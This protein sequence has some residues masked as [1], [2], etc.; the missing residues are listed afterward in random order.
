[1]RY[2][3]LLL[4]LCIPRILPTRFL[5][6]SPSCRELL[7][8]RFRH[9]HKHNHRMTTV[10]LNQIR[11]RLDV[12]EQRR[13][14]FEWKSEQPKRLS[15]HEVWRHA[16]LASPYLVGAPDDR[17]AE[18]F[19][20]VFLNV[21][22]IG[23]EGKICPVPLNQT[24]EFMQ[25]F[26]HLLEEYGVRNRDVPAS[27]IQSAREPFLKYFEHGTP[28]GV[29]MFAEY[30]APATPIL[31]KYGKRQHL[32][33]LL[34]D[35]T[36]RLA[37]AN[38]YNDADLLVAVRDD[39][40]SRTF[41]IPTYKER[42]EGK[43]HIT[44]Q[45]HRIEFGDDDLVLPL[46]FDDYFLF[47][48]CEHIHYRMPTDFDADAAIIIRNPGLFMER[49]IATFLERFPGWIPMA[50]KVTYYDPYRDYSKF[51]VPEMAKHFGYAYQKEVRVAFRP[52]KQASTA[53][54]PLFLS[55]G[56]MTDYADIVAI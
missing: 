5:H 56:S 43:S 30:D 44:F 10:S 45:G 52:R 49:L 40:T 12:M 39:E 27:L 9:V 4:K 23:P 3:R 55:I 46:V 14:H 36:L 32:E 51:S 7:R 41:F 6:A 28:I 16:Y 22:E 15:R 47:S 18:R 48:M 53:L 8:F 24:D 34:K 19:R 37:N 13:R 50:G 33:L 38:S 29:T 1:M 26:T 11:Q 20:S 25:V 2:W 54:E 31:V 35:G 42:L 21:S 17:V